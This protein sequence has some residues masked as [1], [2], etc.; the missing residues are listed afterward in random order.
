MQ[1]F[2]TQTLGFAGCL[3][4][5]AAFSITALAAVKDQSRIPPPISGKNP[6]NVPDS[7]FPDLPDGLQPSEGSDVPSNAPKALPDGQR[8][9]EEEYSNPVEPAEPYDINDIPALERIK[10]TI[11]IAKRAVDAFADVG[12]RY[13]D[14]GLYDY[15]TLEEYVAKTKPGKQL[16]ADVKKHGFKDIVE[17]NTAIMNVSFAFGSLLEDQEA[18]IRLQIESVKKD[19]SLSPE[20]KQRIIASLM[21]LIPTK[22]NIEII[23]ELQKLP[24]YQQKLNLL[25]AFE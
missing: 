15:P 12:S 22:E 2:F 11:D 21:A 18:D 4:L 13:D 25:E 10:L 17:W 6:P 3:W 23:K 24:A 8:P 20:K 16:E 1:R 7:L 5:L 14:K 19:K 9:A